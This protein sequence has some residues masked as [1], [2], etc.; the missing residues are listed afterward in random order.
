MSRSSMA[1]ATTGSSKISP[2]WLMPRLVVSTIDWPSVAAVDDL[3]QRRG[4]L[5]GQR[6]VAELVDDQQLGGG[7]EPHGVGPAA[8]DR[9][10][11][12]AGDEVGGGGVV[13]AVAGVDGGVPEAMASMV[14]PTPGGPM[15]STLPPSSTNRSVGQV[16]QQLG[17]DRGLGV[18]VE[19][20]EPPVGRQAGQPPARLAP[21]GRGRVDLDAEQPFEHLDVGGVVGVVEHR[22]ERVGGGVE[23]QVGQVGTQLLV[24]PV[25]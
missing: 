13:D 22:G 18:G 3:E 15:N 1:A 14:L 5:A 23:L 9:G 6:Q 17:G 11:V 12:A 24:G 7:E 25:G 20:V 16:T 4:G 21:S 19:V 2:H 8:L 10:L